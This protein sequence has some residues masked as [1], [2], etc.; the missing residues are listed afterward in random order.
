MASVCYWTT[1]V[2]CLATP[3]KIFWPG[4]QTGWT[5]QVDMHKDKWTRTHRHVPWFKKI[6]SYT[7]LYYLL[8]SIKRKGP[9][10]G[11][12]CVCIC[13]FGFMCRCAHAVIGRPFS[14][15]TKGQKHPR[16]RLTSL[17]STKI[18]QKV[19]QK[20]TKRSTSPGAAG[21][22]IVQGGWGWTHTHTHLG[23]CG[24]RMG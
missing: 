13:L 20:S 6:K 10:G 9:K 11:G 16:L 12:V 4:R 1:T 7:I 14:T 15:W 3:Y 24:R 8:L 23:Q 19:D 18:D 5:G 17:D 22:P 21:A 2:S